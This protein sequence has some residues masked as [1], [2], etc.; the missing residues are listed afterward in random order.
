MARLQ[1]SVQFSG[2]RHG[3]MSKQP[4][5]YGIVNDSLVLLPEDVAKASASDHQAIWAIKTYGE[6]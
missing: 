4:L 6:A 2:I 5:V 3:R 1:R